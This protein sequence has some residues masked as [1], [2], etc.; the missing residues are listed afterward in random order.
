MKSTFE[1]DPIKEK[2][3]IRKHHISFETA[4]RV[5]ADPFALVEQDRIENGEYR[6]RTLGL[7]NDFLILLVVA[8]TVSI[9]EDGT[10][11]ISII[12]ARRA[13]RKEKRLY[14][15]NCSLRD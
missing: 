7:V 5:F 4:I 3:N 10:E 2:S 13:G 8:H 9:N 6:R 11:V 12:S 1:W 15:E 14:G